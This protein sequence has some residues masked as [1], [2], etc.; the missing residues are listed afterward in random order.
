MLTIYMINILSNLP[1]LVEVRVDLEKE[2]EETHIHRIHASTFKTF[3]KDVLIN[4]TKEYGKKYRTTLK[5]TRISRYQDTEDSLDNINISLD[6]KPSKV[7]VRRSKLRQRHHQQYTTPYL[8]FIPQVHVPT[9]A[10]TTCTCTPTICTYV[11]TISC[12]PHKHGH[13][14]HCTFN[15]I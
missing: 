14:T 4:G 9:Y 2:R 3:F 1:L 5:M 6:K 11:P 10:S 12:L 15:S 7:T 8:V 13:T